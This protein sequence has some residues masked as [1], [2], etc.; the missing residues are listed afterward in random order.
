MQHLI[1]EAARRKDESISDVAPSS[2]Q[3]EEAHFESDPRTFI[4]R[5]LDKIEKNVGPACG[6]ENIYQDDSWDSLIFQLSG[7]GEFLNIGKMML[8]YIDKAETSDFI[9]LPGDKTTVIEVNPKCPRDKLL[10]ILSD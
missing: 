7:T 10:Q 2:V 4:N 3:K 8:G 6:L 1:L 5:I 9:L